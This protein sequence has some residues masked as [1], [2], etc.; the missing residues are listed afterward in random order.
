MVLAYH[1][2]SILLLFLGQSLSWHAYERNISIFSKDASCI[3]DI[4]V[5]LTREI[6]QY[7]KLW[8]YTSNPILK[9]A[10]MDN[11]QK[12]LHIHGIFE[13]LKVIY[14]NQHPKNCSTAKFLISPQRKTC[15]F[16]C[17][18][19]LDGVAL[20][21]ALKSGRVLLDTADRVLSWEV[22]NTFCQSNNER[23]KTC[24]YEPWSSCSLEDAGFKPHEDR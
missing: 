19:H 3:E 23:G 16:G 2:V 17:E 13:A 11:K 9:D 15:G 4:S 1:F 10:V 20:A 6:F 7:L 24:Y 18:I 21:L 12:S 22:N 8:S 14:E 5:S